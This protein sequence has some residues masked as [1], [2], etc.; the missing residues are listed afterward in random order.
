[1]PGAQDIA[2]GYRAPLRD[3]SEITGRIAFFDERVDVVVDGVLQ[4]RPITPWSVPTDR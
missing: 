2:W 1:M 3:A 4:A